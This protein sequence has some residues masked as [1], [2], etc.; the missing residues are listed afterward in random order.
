MA[1]ILKKIEAYKREE[2]A[3][4]RAARPIGD[5]RAAARDAAAVRPFRAALDQ[6]IAR[7][8]RSLEEVVFFHRAS[9]TLIL[10]DLIENFERE[11]LHGPLARALARLGGVL[12]PRGKTPL[13]LRLSFLRGM[14]RMRGTVDWMLACAPERVVIAHGQWFARDGAAVVARAFAWVRR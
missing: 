1:D 7:G 10:A 6:R 12:A 2:I 8:S 5:V 9:R 11:R 14:D 4:A 3:A 13:D